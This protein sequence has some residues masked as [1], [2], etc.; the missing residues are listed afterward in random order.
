MAELPNGITGV[1]IGRIGNIVGYML[2]GKNII[3]NIGKSGPHNDNQKANETKLG[4]ISSLAKVLDEF[5]AFGFKNSKRKAGTSIRSYAIGLNKKVAVK[6]KYPK[7]KIDFKKLIVSEGSVAAPKN[8]SVKLN[9]RNLEFSW[10]ADI[11]ADGADE[12]DQVM[13]LAYLPEGAKAIKV[14]SGARR[15]E[16]YQKLKLPGSKKDYEI[17]V[18]MSYIADDRSAASPSVY[19]GKHI[20]TTNS[21]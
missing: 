11:D 10:E 15:T 16:E 19:L 9:G 8:A 12:R 14:L 18:Y 13:L 17:E 7:Q 21:K 5:L 2:N 4:I 3:R 1:F 20:W 6:G